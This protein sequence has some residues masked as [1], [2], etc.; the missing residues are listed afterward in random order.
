MAN[1]VSQP[2]ISQ[3]IKRLEGELGINLLNH[4]RNSVE[5]TSDAKGVLKYATDLF[6]A[7][8][9]FETQIEKVRGGHSGQV[10]IGISNSL[11]SYVL[12]PLIKKLNKR[13]PEIEPIIKIGKT[14]DQVSLLERGQID[15]GITINN[16]EL[17]KYHLKSISKGRFILCGSKNA[18]S[19]LL[20]TGPRPEVI[21]LKKQIVEKSFSSEVEIE[22]WSTIYSLVNSGY[23]IGLLPDFMIRGD[24][25]LMN[26]NNIFNYRSIE[27]D[28]ISFS[29]SKLLGANYK[30][31]DDML[32]IH[33]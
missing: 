28:I 1:C 13:Y 25:S 6:Y 7:I 15:I 26:Y 31:I 29:K 19:R 33:L 11:V 10:R 9:L 12:A 18:P 27:Y 22:S 2:A 5:F 4:K 20:T 16:N 3:G 30:I 23:G 24:K 17:D 8:E 14:S 32:N 21:D